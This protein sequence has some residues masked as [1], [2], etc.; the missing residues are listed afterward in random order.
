MKNRTTI[1]A[2]IWTFN[3]DIKRFE[4]VLASIKNQVNKIVVVDNCSSNIEETENLCKKF[5]SILIKIGFNSGVHALNVGMKFILKKIKPEF[6]LLLDQDSILYPNAIQ[7]II[8]KIKKAGIE[9]IFGAVQIYM[10]SAQKEHK[11]KFI[12]IKYGIFSGS[13]IRA[14]LVRKGLKAREEF[15]LDQADFDFYYNIR[16]LGF[17]TFLYG[18]KLMKHRLGRKIKLPLFQ[19]KTLKE[20][21]GWKYQ[22][23][24]RFYYIVRNSTVLLF[25]RKMDM[26]YYLTQIIF[27][28][29]SL[30]FM[31][32]ILKTLKALVFGLIHGLL[33]KL[34]PF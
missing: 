4:K 24:W 14:E 34:G 9:K 25:E 33:K 7:T 19:P 1:C 12:P 21:E 32:E 15:F 17:P 13:L 3:P 11:G 5:N 10:Y 16:K 29:I 8:S 6:I 31:N 18:K 30:I 28:T 27:Y 23:P 20:R 26:R 2:L 22:P